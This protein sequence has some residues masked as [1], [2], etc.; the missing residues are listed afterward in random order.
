MT[1]EDLD[2]MRDVL[3]GVSMALI[4]STRADP[5]N[6]ST[7]LRL[8]AQSHPDGSEAN[9]TLSEIATG[10]QVFGETIKQQPAKPS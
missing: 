6:V 3:L 10:V 8:F 2:T 1:K 5:A 9:R 4:T 7:A